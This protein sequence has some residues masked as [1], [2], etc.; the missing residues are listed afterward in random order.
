VTDKSV[1]IKID[2]NAAGAVKVFGDL[3]KAYQTNRAEAEKLRLQVAL[4]RAELEKLGRTVSKSAPEYQALQKE[5]SGLARQLKTAESETRQLERAMARAEQ[6]SAKTAA[7]ANAHKS[8]IAGYSGSFKLLASSI[9]AVVAGLTTGKF[10]GTLGEFD[11]LNASLKTVTG[12]MQAAA[13]ASAGLRKFAAETP[14]ELQDVTDAFI[15]LRS[16]G[17]D[18]SERSLRSYGN[19]AAA[20]GKPI[21]QFIEAVADASTGE[22]ER[23]KEFGIK[24]SKQGDEIAFTF[25]GVT[26]K[27]KN[28]ATDI[29]NYLRGIGETQF[30]TGMADQ[31]DTI[32]GKLS[33]LSDTLS[34]FVD[35]LGNLG[36]RDALKKGFD[37][38]IEFLGGF[39]K[40]LNAVFGTGLQSQLDAYDLQIEAVRKRI[41][42]QREMNKTPIIGGLLADPMDI[43]RDEQTLSEMTAMREKIRASIAE[44]ERKN[45]ALLNVSSPKPGAGGGGSSKSAESAARKAAQDQIQVLEAQFSELKANIENETEVMKASKDLELQRAGEDAEK[46]LEIQRRYTKNAEVLKNELIKAEIEYKKKVDALNEDRGESARLVAEI[47]NLE[48]ELATTRRLSGIEAE[49]QALAER[50]A[51]RQRARE[52]QSVF[53]AAASRRD[54][55]LADPHDLMAR[56]ERMLQGTKAGAALANQKSLQEARDALNAG[57]IDA[58]EFE[59]VLA[60]IN[61][62]TSTVGQTARELGL[63]MTSSFEKA[64]TSG[65]KFSDVLRGLA[66]DIQQILVRKL[67]TEPLAEWVSKGISALM[68]AVGAGAGTNSSGGNADANTASNAAGLVSTIVAAFLHGGGRVGVDR[69][70]FTRAVPIGAFAGAARYHSGG[71]AGLKP[72]EV[73]AILKRREEVL[74][75]TDPRH[76]DNL[77]AGSRRR[78]E[79]APAAAGNVNIVN[80]LDPR[81]VGSYLQ[82]AQGERLVMNILSRNSGAVQKMVSRG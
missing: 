49:K 39:Q 45:E 14:Y 55:D 26:T 78:P 33:N 4:G 69:P 65:E 40:Q 47:N 9:G 44:S 79:A 71:I 54:S 22:F 48:R 5:V 35:F 53:E 34:N 20:M 7:G 1:S 3:S 2:G 82:T 29:V 17:L 28:N 81:L 77:A 46:K 31:M 52:M 59:Q 63:T 67:V 37:G 38:A 30:A 56:R 76:R 21:M 75:E 64:I 41:K 11:R 27:V 6:A 25:Q 24:A 19:T 61:D 66:K 8:A 42:G 72:D 57:D 18:A 73:P 32:D 36:I 62:Q 13:L 51:A 80:V 43:A 68:G 58:A 16:L 10:V 12:S 50:E 15:R 74:P 70:A 60:R 23:L